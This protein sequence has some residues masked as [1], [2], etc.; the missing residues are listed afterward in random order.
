MGSALPSAAEVNLDKLVLCPPG[1]EF[2]RFRR[3]E[4]AAI[5]NGAA[6]LF[7]LTSGLVWNYVWFGE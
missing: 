4:A 6:T 7:G 5:A 1:C 2:D 3:S